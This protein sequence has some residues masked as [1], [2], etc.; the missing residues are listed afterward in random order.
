MTIHDHMLVF[1]Y[2]TVVPMGI[3][4]LAVAFQM[5]RGDL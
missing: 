1:G 3:V 5:F 2:V 4:L